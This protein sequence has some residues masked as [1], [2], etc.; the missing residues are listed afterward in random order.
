VS[1]HEAGRDSLVSEQC[2]RR[3]PLGDHGLVL[4]RALDFFLLA[5][6]LP[7]R[8][9]DLATR[10][11]AGACRQ[12]SGGAMCPSDPGSFSPVT[13]DRRRLPT[14]EAERACDA[15]HVLGWLLSALSEEIHY[16]CTGGSSSVAPS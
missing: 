3:Q 5:P 8:A 1:R 10:R 2:H 4:R 6:V 9:H 11:A 7:T 14:S 12:L 15:R 16:H 13:R